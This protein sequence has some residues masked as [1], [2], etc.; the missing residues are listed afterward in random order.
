MSFYYPSP[1]TWELLLKN[2]GK[3]SRTV[4]IWPSLGDILSHRVQCMD[5]TSP[6]GL[7]TG[8]RKWYVLS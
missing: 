8:I 1:S 2:G 3:N 7:C 6:R 5:I 4:N